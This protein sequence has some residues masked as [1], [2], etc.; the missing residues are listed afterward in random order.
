MTRE[1]LIAGHSHIFAMGAPQSYRG[2]LALLKTSDRVGYFVMEEWNGRRSDEYW[3]KLVD[4]ST[5]RDVLIAYNGN[6]HH[7]S[8]LFAPRP[9]F[10]FVDDYVP[11]MLD[12]ATLVPRR[13][14]QAFFE[15]T[16]NQLRLLIPKLLTA[17]CASVRLVGTPPP[18]ADLHVFSQM[19]R[20]SEFAKRYS[21][22]NGI[23]L[24]RA[25]LSPTLL[26]LKLWRVVQ[27]V[28]ANAATDDRVRFVP[29]PRQATDDVGFLSKSYY[30]YVPSDIT[31]ANRSFG[32]LMTTCALQTLRT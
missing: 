22:S 28:T 3:R 5:G 21:Q 19:I 7:S 25:A 20:D 8:F 24:Q 9:L 15:P 10:D 31:H 6:Q 4:W 23:D 30:D 17:G 1:Y 27:E 16:V 29:V 11:M 26:L 14:I 13:L 32:D 12:G 18:K 2:P